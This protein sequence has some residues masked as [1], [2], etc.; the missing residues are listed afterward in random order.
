MRTS[1]V[2]L[3]AALAALGT[4]LGCAAAAA[5]APAAGNKTSYTPAVSRDGRYVAFASDATNLVAGDTNGKRDIFVRDT[6]AKKTR[7]VSIG[8]GTTQA[9]GSSFWPKISDNGRY[10]SF[11]SSATNLVAGDTNA[12]AD[13]FR[14]DTTT[15][16]VLRLSVGA[17]GKQ[18]NG[19]SAN[20][21]MDATGTKFVFSSTATNLVT[22]DTNS[23]E[24]VFV[25]DVTT[26]T[27]RRISRSSSGGQ[28]TSGTVEMTT[29]SP[30]AAYVGFV[31]ELP[32]GRSDLGYQWTRSSNYLSELSD[33]A[34]YYGSV[35]GTNHGVAWLAGAYA[36]GGH[37]DSQLATAP[38]AG[39]PAL[40]VYLGECTGHNGQTMD[41]NPA[42]TMMAVVIGDW[43]SATTLYL[44]D[45]DLDLWD[46]APDGNAVAS[47]ARETITP[48]LAA[49]GQSVAYADDSG[50]IRKWTHKTGA[51]ALI[52]TR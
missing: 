25:R 21:D 15:G 48:A 7:R 23:T 35:A 24:D 9:N 3:V 5:P 4:G 46:D 10:V 13:A 44:F 41:A 32:G 8:A 17:G 42:G 14:V 30:N 47:L 29:I 52:S 40:D 45:K 2:G 37:C 6:V 33:A 18:A 36:E 19:K 49:N 50:Q 11:I 51:I 12:Q 22:G 1:R 27:T 43:G 31:Y 38:Q 16:A 39:D 28:I 26:A 34:E 20:L